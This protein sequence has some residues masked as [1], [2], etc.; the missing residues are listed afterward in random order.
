[1]GLAGIGVRGWAGVSPVTED[2]Q[3][4]SCPLQLLSLCDFKTDDIFTWFK[5][6]G[7]HA[8]L[9]LLL[10]GPEGHVDSLVWI[11]FC[12][13]AG[14]QVGPGGGTPVS[15]TGVPHEAP[16]QQPRCV[17]PMFLPR[18]HAANTWRS[19]RLTGKPT[20]KIQGAGFPCRLGRLSQ[21]A[22]AG[23]VVC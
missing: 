20:G 7:V 6:K 11:A 23:G 16:Q 12:L 3:P 17:C 9:F 15:L 18:K 13:G 8:G 4:L 21:Q 2:T 19:A 22:M 5:N 1:M 10:C 14:L